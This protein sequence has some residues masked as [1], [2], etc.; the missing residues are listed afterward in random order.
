MHIQMG[1]AQ[2]KRKY[3]SKVEGEDSIK[4]TQCVQKKNFAHTSETIVD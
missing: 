1:E 2:N 4:Q 3:G